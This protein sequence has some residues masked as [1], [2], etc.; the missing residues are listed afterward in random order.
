[1]CIAADGTTL[2]PLAIVPRLTTKVELF[3]VGY[4][5]QHLILAYREGK[6]IDSKLFLR[7]AREIFAPDVMRR[8]AE[9]RYEGPGMLLLNGCSAHYDDEFFE[10]SADIG[11][12]PVFLSP[13]SSGQTQALD[14]RLFGI[15]KREIGRIFPLDWLT[16][17]SKQIYRLLGASIAAATPPNI[18]LAFKQVRIHA[19]CNPDH[20]GLEVRV[21][22]KTARQLR[23]LRSPEE[24][25]RQRKRV[26]LIS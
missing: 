14:V 17:Q 1:V 15:H 9:I 2:K 8:R 26:N 22:I 5:P 20:G 19:I 24:E 6:F 11:I 3:E 10:I 23:A 13:H 4:T 21:D 18:I 12:Y 7:L 25:A 16:I